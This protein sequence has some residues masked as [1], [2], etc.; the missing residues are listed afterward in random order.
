MSHGK[1]SLK[2][3]FQHL[4]SCAMLCQCKGNF[5]RHCACGLYMHIGLLVIIIK[6]NGI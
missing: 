6:F 1:V 2:R 4:K 5:E 3:C